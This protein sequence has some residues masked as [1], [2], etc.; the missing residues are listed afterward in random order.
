MAILRLAYILDV[1][2][3]VEFFKH[4][5]MICTLLL[6]TTRTR[7]K[8]TKMVTLDHAKPFSQ[9]I[10]WEGQRSFYQKKG[11]NAW[12]DTVPFY[13]TSN[14]FISYCYAELILRFIQDWTQKDPASA[15]KPFYIVELGTGSGQFSFYVLKKLTELLAHFN[16]QNIQLRYI[17]TDFVEDNIKA[18]QQ[19]KRLQPFVEQKILDFA[20]FDLEQDSEINTIQFDFKLSKDQSCENPLIVIAN[21]VFDSVVSDI[22]KIKQGKIYSSLVSLATPSDN[23][24]NGLPK[25]WRKVKIRHTDQEI[26]QY[27]SDPRLNKTLSVYRESIK[28][29][30][31]LFPNSALNGLEHLQKLSRHKLFLISSDKGFTNTYDLDEQPYPEIDFHGSFSLMVNFHAIASYFKQNQGDYFLPTARE[32]LTTGIFSSA[33][34]L[35]ELKEVSYLLQNKINGFSPID[36]Y[37]LAIEIE[38]LYPKVDLKFLASLLELSHWD[39]FIFSIISER[40]VKLIE[41]EDTEVVDQII[42]NIPKLVDNFYYLPKCDDIFFTLGLLFYAIDDFPS[43]IKYYNL[44]AQHF[45]PGYELFYNLGLSYFNNKNFADAREQFEKALLLK[46]KNLALKK[47][48]ASCK[49]KKA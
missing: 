28:N 32:G 8:K 22:F 35:A 33:C 39:P 12:A 23:L 45:K 25:S 29:S 11:I 47:M 27:Y 17:M 36:F 14:P 41:K 48:I 2:M 6:R 26:E 18:W 20:R 21:Y 19:H 30:Y 34:P 13:I 40:L 5:T 38:K 43:A 31:I 3:F 44:S 7:M 42:L 9:S 1:N 4:L 49:R 10:F 46:P 15:K 16:L 24:K 37:N